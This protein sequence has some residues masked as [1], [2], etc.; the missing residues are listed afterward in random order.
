MIKS[1]DKEQ[2]YANISDREFSELSSI[3]PVDSAF[4]CV[5]S[6]LSTDTASL[7]ES[8]ET[9]YGNQNVEYCNV[10]KCDYDEIGSV[11][12]NPF[13]SDTKQELNDD[14]E[15]LSL[16]S[17]DLEEDCKSLNLYENYETLETDQI[18]NIEFPKFAGET[19]PGDLEMKCLKSDAMNL[20]IK[21]KTKESNISSLKTAHKV[22]E[23]C[24][25]ECLWKTELLLWNELYDKIEK[26]KT[27]QNLVLQ[28]T[29]DMF[30]AIMTHQTLPALQVGKIDRVAQTELPSDA[31]ENLV[32]ISVSKDGNCFTRAISMALYE[33]GEYHQIFRTKILVEGVLHKDHYLDEDYLHLGMKSQESNQRISCVYAEFTGNYMPE[34]T[35]QQEQSDEEITSMVETVY[36]RDTLQVRKLGVKMG[37]WQVFQASSILGRPIISVFP[38]RGNPSYRNYF[39][40]TVYPWNKEH[41]SN[42]PLTI[43]WA[44]S[45][46]GGPINH[47]V[48]LLPP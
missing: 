18:T 19:K 27:F 40:R 30:Q 38:E 25:L 35:N 20:E 5:N 33:T 29:D 1:E 9:Q 14:Y 46:A 24:R 37:M 44:P 16:K 34:E 23:A 8:R 32:P 21:D 12:E 43:M 17:M 6:N 36:K 26:C 28:G 47:F 7:L 10:L 41:R 11:N 39:N 4:S 48:P 45:V 42:Q 15:I 22:P 2:E 31:P 13:R 3:G